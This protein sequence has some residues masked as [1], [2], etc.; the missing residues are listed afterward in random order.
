MLT[1]QGRLRYRRLVRLSTGGLLG[2]GRG[3]RDRGFGR[4][5]AAALSE[6]PDGDLVVK[7]LDVAHETRGDSA[8]TRC[9]T[10]KGAG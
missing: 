6:K 4:T 1:E 2:R 8:E 10:K 7:A 3:Y 9:A 5:R